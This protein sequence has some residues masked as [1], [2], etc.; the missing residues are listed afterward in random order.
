MDRATEL[1]GQHAK[2]GIYDATRCITG[3]ATAR[4]DYHLN[5][6]C[7]PYVTISKVHVEIFVAK[8]FG[9]DLYEFDNRGF[10]LDN[11]TVQP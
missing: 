8:F 9:L 6:V 1:D 2:A 5:H 7:K 4:Y 10:N 3:D 11:C